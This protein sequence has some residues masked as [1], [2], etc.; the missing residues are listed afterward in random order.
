MSLKKTLQLLGL[1]LVPVFSVALLA[2]PTASAAKCNVSVLAYPS[3]YSGLEG[4]TNKSGSDSGDKPEIKKLNDI[5]VIALNA[6]QWIIVTVGYVALA[7]IIWGG[8]QYIIAQGEPSKI[9]SAKSSLMNAIIGL[10][11]A[12]SAVIIIQTVQ[13]AINGD[14]F[15]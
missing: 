4:C 13:R 7:M 2:S 3:W 11:I 15:P 12:L 10:V 5:W 8:F 6:A 1:L 14:L 9:E